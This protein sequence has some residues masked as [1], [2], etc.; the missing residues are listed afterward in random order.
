MAMNLTEHA[1]DHRAPAFRHREGPH[2]RVGLAQIARR[3]PTG[4]EGRA[5]DPLGDAIHRRVQITTCHQ[6]FSTY[7]FS[8]LG[9]GEAADRFQRALVQDILQFGS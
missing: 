1:R 9:E 8:T 5:T 4:D 2:L 6:V 7:I 3:H